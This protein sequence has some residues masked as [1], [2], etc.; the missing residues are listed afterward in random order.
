[1]N[2]PIK[3]S[4]EKTLNIALYYR[5]VGLVGVKTCCEGPLVVLRLAAGGADAA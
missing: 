1:L 2:N 5:I 4:D 3:Q